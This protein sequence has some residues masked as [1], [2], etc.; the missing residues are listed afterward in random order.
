MVDPYGGP[1]VTA[2]CEPLS[3]LTLS[4]TMESWIVTFELYPAC[5]PPPR[6]SP[7][8]LLT[9]LPAMVQLSNRA[10]A[11]Q[12]QEAPP[13]SRPAEFS[14]MRPFLRIRSSAVPPARYTPPPEVAARLRLIWPWMK[15]R[16]PSRG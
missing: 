6:A 12:L 11:F 2:S 7:R 5:T 8:T 10:F 13:P 4:Q 14:V 15:Y 1:S 16:G 3:L 9:T